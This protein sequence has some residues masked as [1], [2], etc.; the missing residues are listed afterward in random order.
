MICALHHRVTPQ[1]LAALGAA[2]ASAVQSAIVAEALRQGVDP[3][4]ALAVANRESGFNQSAVGRAGELGI[5]QLMPATAAGLGVNPS[6][7]TQNI[8]GGVTYLAEMYARFGNWASALAAYNAG[9]TRVA[10]GTTPS[11][12][13]SYAQGV[14]AD[15]PN[16]VGWSTQP[17]AQMETPLVSPGSPGVDTSAYALTLAPQ[18]A[19]AAPEPASLAPLLVFGGIIGLGLFLATR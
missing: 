14:M 3:S 8:Q 4:I 12:A 9:P 16:W 13:A 6:D 18:E 2:V 15:A 11:A 5:F 17:E 10:Q 19:S 1:G 7:P